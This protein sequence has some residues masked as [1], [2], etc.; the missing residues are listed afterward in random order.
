MIGRVRL[1]FGAAFLSSVLAVAAEAQTVEEIIARNLEARGGKAA[2][3]AVESLRQTSVLK[4]EGAEIPVLVIGKRPNLLRQELSIAGLT[5]IEAFDGSVA[6]AQNRLLGMPTPTPLEGA[7]A[8]TLRSQSSFDGILAQAKARG[9]LIEL[10]GVEK[11]AGRPAHSLRLTSSEHRVLR[12]YVDVTTGLEVRVSYDTEA[13]VFVQDL[14]DYREV[15]GLKIPFLIATYIGGRPQGQLAVTTVEINVP[16]DASLFTMPAAT[17][18]QT[19][20]V[21]APPAVA[22]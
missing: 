7:H 12:C 11:I 9:D 1:A 21:A 10:V 20:H 4:V 19:R 22:P 6:W 2:I 5:A 18:Q 15:S 17:G 14:S 13:G 8:Q 3:E 16:V